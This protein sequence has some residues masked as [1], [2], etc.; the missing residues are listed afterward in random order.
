MLTFTQHKRVTFACLL[1]LLLSGC[2]GYLEGEASSSAAAAQAIQAPSEDSFLQALLDANPNGLLPHQ[3]MQT[4]TAPAFTKSDG[5]ALD[6]SVTCSLSGADWLAISSE[7]TVSLATGFDVVQDYAGTLQVTYGCEAASDSTNN[8]SVD[9]QMGDGDNDG[10]SDKLEHLYS[11]APIALNS[12]YYWGTEA[13]RTMLGNGKIPG[14]HKLS[15]ETAVLDPGTDDSNNV[16]DADGDGLTNR[17]EVLAGR[18]IF[19]RLSNGSLGTATNVALGTTP[20][21]CTTLDADND[22]DIDLACTN[23]NDWTYQVLLNN[24]SGTFVAQAAALTG[25]QMPDGIIAAHLNSGGNIDLVIANNGTSD[26][27]ICLGNGNGTFAACSTQAAG[28][29]PAAIAAA[30]LDGDGNID[31]ITGNID[32]DNISVFLGNGDGTLDAQTT[33]TAGDFPYDVA[34]GDCDG[35]SDADIFVTNRDS[36]TL[37][38]FKGSGDGTFAAQVTVNAGDRPKGMAVAD[39]NKDGALDITHAVDGADA[40]GVH[41]GNGDC[42]FDAIDTYSVPS[43]PGLGFRIADFDGDGELDIFMTHDLAAS[44]TASVIFGNGSFGTGEI[45]GSATSYTTGAAPAFAAA[46]DWNAD[47]CTDAAVANNDSNNVS[48]FLNSCTE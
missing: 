26:I 19:E 44:T 42:T 5:S 32:S 39:L 41:L 17:A 11:G 27:S 33:V 29:T 45:F 24:G 3:A 30:D 2:V 13:N 12:G 35:D 34:V 25:G 22:G 46:G 36:D 47:G 21:A 4:F 14:S 7:R 23:Y 18:S 10:M 40:V 38:V 15:D 9:V 37:S 28:T 6:I 43:K 16:G 20:Q 8:D 48:I 1:S 31:V